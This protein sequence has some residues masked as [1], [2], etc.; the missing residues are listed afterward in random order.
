[1]FPYQNPELSPEA[2]TE[3]LL[4][5]MTTAEK[6]AQMRLHVRLDVGFDPAEF[7]EKYPDS[8][9]LTYHTM[10]LEP[11]E[12]NRMQ[13]HAVEHT[14]LGIP[15][16]LHGESL[17]GFMCDGAT[18]YPQALALGATFDDALVGEISSEIG[19]SV[20]AYGVRETYAPNL[21][22]S[23]EPRW[24][25]C[26]ENYGED[27]YLTSRLGVAYIRGIQS[28]G[29]YSSPKH[30]LAHG[31]PERGI[32]I[33]PVHAGEREIRETMLRPF[34]AAF[35]E[36]KAKSVMPA[37]SE[38]D[39]VPLH[40]SRYWLTDVLRGEFGFDGPA[41]S[42][43]G[44][45]HMLENR[46]HLTPDVTK[47]GE[48][49]LHAGIDVEAPTTFGFGPELAQ[50]AEKDPALMA[51]VDQAVR[52]ILLAKF[53]L[54]LFENP[55]ADP[56]AKKLL[57]TK[58]SLALAEKA[59][60]ESCV[61]LKNNGILPLDPAKKQKLAFIGPGAN[62][63]HLG[64]YTVPSTDGQIPSLYEVVRARIGELAAFAQGSNIAYTTPAMLREAYDTAMAA[65]VVVLVLATNSAHYGKFDWGDAPEGKNKAPAV[66]CGEGYDVTSLAFTDGQTKL[67]RKIAAAK[68]PTILLT[69]TGRPQLLGEAERF[70]DAVMQVWYPGER[71]AHAIDKL[72]F[73]EANP[74]GRLPVTFPK[75]DGQIPCFYNHK[76]SAVH[77]I[78]DAKRRKNGRPDAPGIYYVFCD[79]QPQHAFGEGLSYTTFGYSGLKVRQLAPQEFEVSVTVTNT[80]DREG[81]EVVLL[82]LSDLYCRFTPL[83]KQ[84]RGFRRIHLKPGQKKRVAFTLGFEDLSFVNEKMER[85]VEPGE[86][87]VEIGSE[88]AVFEVK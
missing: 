56:K 84:L 12:I 55:Y 64:D 44:A 2:R 86:F 83:V 8:I 76:P 42:D 21:D 23:R 53:R 9:G 36:A 29:V 88:Q 54:G 79:Q 74:S 13:K 7:D 35:K 39:G 6:V 33:A 38:L 58:R 25:R 37:Y 26:E 34:E 75:E 69:M 46:H 66:I 1:M 71:G 11:E 47:A 81:D 49:A 22:L 31:S 41:I 57:K 4:S 16:F 87:R 61:L 72:L 10:D 48:I 3:D 20:R 65:D 32:N 59:A 67:L 60:I 78:P 85:E 14:R 43:W 62:Y 80:G 63:T 18:V 24:G 73:G 19:R 15:L 30:Y 40:A 82:Y 5:R 51:E 17:H 52:R 45:V 50:R 68:K 77:T 27:P 28:Q 70:C